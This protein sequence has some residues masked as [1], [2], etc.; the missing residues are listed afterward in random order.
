[1]FFL[2]QCHQKEENGYTSDKYSGDAKNDSLFTI[3]KFIYGDSFWINDGMEKG[4]KV[5]LIGVD[6]PESMS[7]FKKKKHPM[8]W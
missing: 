3:P 4:Q 8:V 2:C 1:M 7:V 6:A 5:R